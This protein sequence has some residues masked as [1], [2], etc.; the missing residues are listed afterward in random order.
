MLGV[1]TDKGYWSRV[2][3]SWMR[4]NHP[5]LTALYQEIYERKSSNY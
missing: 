4:E 1:T 3:L 5:E 2:I